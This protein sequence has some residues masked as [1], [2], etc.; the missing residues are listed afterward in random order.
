MAGHHIRGCLVTFFFLYYSACAHI[1]VGTPGWETAS[2]RLEE[3]YHIKPPPT[4]I[5]RYQTREQR[6]LHSVG[7]INPILTPSL[8]ALEPNIYRKITEAIAYC[9]KIYTGESINI[10]FRYTDTTLLQNGFKILGE[11]MVYDTGGIVTLYAPAKDGMFLVALHEI[12]HV[13]GFSS[14]LINNG[15]Y[16]G[17]AVRAINK[18]HLELQGSHWT[19]ESELSV[20]KNVDIMLASISAET[21]TSLESLFV[22]VDARGWSSSA[23]SKNGDCSSDTSCVR[24]SWSLPGYCHKQTRDTKEDPLLWRVIYPITS[25]VVVAIITGKRLRLQS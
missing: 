1:L 24:S 25:V 2:S 5:Q 4:K 6:S 3:S 12:L 16:T 20:G 10:E 13:A 11:A 22:P 7:I 19:P 18:G 23:C 21:V 14:S 9:T 17:N 8:N 15:I